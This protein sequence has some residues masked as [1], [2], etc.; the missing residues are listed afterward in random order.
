MG[1]V[2]QWTGAKSARK[3]TREATKAQQ[4][5]SKESLKVQRSALKQQREALEQL[6][7]D[8][9]PFRELGATGIGLSGFLTDPQEQTDFITNHPLFQAAIENIQEQTQAGQAAGGRLGSGGTLEALRQNF[10]AQSLPFLDRQT[11]NITNLLS[12]G[13]NAAARSGTAGLQA[14]QTGIQAAGRMGDTITSAGAAQAAGDIARGNILAQSQGDLFQ[15]IIG[16][17]GGA[18][19][20]AGMLGSAG[21]IGGGG[22]LGAALGG[23]LGFFSDERLKEN[24]KVVGKDGDM[25]IIE[26]NYKGIPSTRYVG[27]KAHQVYE[28]DPK[29]VTVTKEG[30][31][32]VSEKYI[33]KRVA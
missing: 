32:T 28:N 33:P 30:Y 22:G 24:I 10:M 14:A 29:A 23:A 16:G 21:A 25:D 2:R 8:L 12:L 5:A 17:L 26:F 1:K 4:E 19:S 3:S 9:A 27:Y 11:Q 31:L 6:R 13:Q 20:G 7:G 15:S 18:A